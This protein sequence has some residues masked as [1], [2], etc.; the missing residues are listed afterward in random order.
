VHLKTHPGLALDPAQLM[1]GSMN[2]DR[3]AAWVAA[4]SGSAPIVYST[5]DPASVASAQQSFGREE[6]AARVEQFFAAL[7]RR[8]VDGGVRRVVVG[9]GETSGAVVTALG[10]TSLGIGEEI[11]PGVPALVAEY[12][13]PLGL[14]LKSG[15]FGAEDFFEK[16]VK[17]IGTA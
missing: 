17:R 1:D 8:L 11:D 7:A 3:A 5:A 10:V 13:G 14:A 12:D 16:A 6:I 2:V 9:G 15:N 4:Q